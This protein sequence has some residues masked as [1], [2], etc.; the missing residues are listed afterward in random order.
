MSLAFDIVDIGGIKT[1]NSALHRNYNIIAASV[2]QLGNC[3]IEAFLECEIGDRLQNIV[4]SPHLVSLYCI[5]GHIGNKD[6]DNAGINAADLFCGSHAVY[7]FH[8]DVH[9]NNIKLRFIFGSDLISIPVYGYVNFFIRT[10]LVFLKI[11]R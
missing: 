1:N 7:E 9:Q 4:H 3:L 6:N 2:L 8:L 11:F 10:F 5:L